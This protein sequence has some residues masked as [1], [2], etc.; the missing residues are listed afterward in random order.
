MNEAEGVLV[1]PP[2]GWAQDQGYQDEVDVLEP[3]DGYWVKNLSASTVQLKI[4]AIEA[5]RALPSVAAPL[6][7]PPANRE[8]WSIRITASSGDVFDAG[9][10]AGMHPQ[11]SNGRDS[12]DRSK[13]PPVPG[14]M[15]SLYFPHASWSRHAGCYGHDVRG[16]YESFDGE[17]PH[18]AWGQVWQFDVQKNFTKEKAGDEVTLNFEGLSEVS[19]EASICLV[20]QWVGS[21]TD[22]RATPVY[23]F[24]QGKKERTIKEDDARFSL[25]VGNETFVALGGR[26]PALPIRTKL[27]QNYP[28]PFNPSTIIR[29][30]IA[31]ASP[32]SIRI[33]DASGSRV[34]DLYS[35][36]R[37]PGVY[38]VGWDARN[39]AG[40]FVASGI[41]FCRFEAGQTI[42][43]RKMLLL[44]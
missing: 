4:P 44:K 5:R 30:E 18:D 8:N 9:C 23:R 1:E 2:Y 11:A 33:Y 12:R 15:V 17:T 28:N 39:D 31:Q 26:L 7:P 43:T 6:R 22:L 24:F 32:V 29:Y 40:Q 16:T 14:E 19:P 42:E 21:V 20:D 41:Y 35:G 13:P 25:V 36:H 34:R 38:E 3:F 10:V 27:H 37:T